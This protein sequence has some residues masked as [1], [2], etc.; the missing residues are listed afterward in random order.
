MNDSEKYENS[1]FYQKWTDVNG[2]SDIDKAVI[3][4]LYQKGIK[5]GMSKDQIFKLVS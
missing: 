5:A 4:L 1:I 3:S 2:F